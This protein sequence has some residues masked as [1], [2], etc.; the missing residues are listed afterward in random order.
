MS[1]NC[2]PIDRCVFYTEPELNE[3]MGGFLT[4]KELK[5]LVGPVKLVE[6]HR[7]SH[8]ELGYWG[9]NILNAI[10]QYI[11]SCISEGTG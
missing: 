9:D 3:I 10:D 1:V 5:D 11:T 8:M 2:V 6:F 7:S 4:V